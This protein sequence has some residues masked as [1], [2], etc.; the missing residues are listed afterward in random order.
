MLRAGGRLYCEELTA[1]GATNDKVLQVLS[2]QH[3]III[4]EQSRL[5]AQS[6]L[7]GQ[8]VFAL[9][10]PSGYMRP[11]GTAFLRAGPDMWMKRSGAGKAGPNPKRR[12]RKAARNSSIRTAKGTPKLSVN[13]IRSGTAFQF[14][15][16]MN[17][18][19]SSIRSCSPICRRRSSSFRAHCSNALQMSFAV[20]MQCLRI[21]ASSC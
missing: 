21:T 4:S 3:G 17:T 8:R 16:I 20:C 13:R 2:F 19:L 1:K 15:L 10:S 11:G 9:L 14:R 7:F 18:V 12:E 5:G 6:E